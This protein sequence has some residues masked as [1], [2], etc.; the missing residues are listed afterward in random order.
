MLR[1]TPVDPSSLLLDLTP[2]PAPPTLSIKVTL[3]IARA[4]RQYLVP[5]WLE[6]QH[7]PLVHEDLSK[8]V[9]CHSHSPSLLPSTPAHFKFV[10]S[11]ITKA[12]LVSALTNV[13][14]TIPTHSRTFWR[15]N[16]EISNNRSEI[17][18][19]GNTFNFAQFFQLVQYLPHAAQLVFNPSDD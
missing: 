4:Q 13:S 2:A 16:E 8:L 12:V 17:T 15:K 6:W 3:Q 9:L 14:V 11:L 7:P 1:V 19:P 5:E 10:L 18:T